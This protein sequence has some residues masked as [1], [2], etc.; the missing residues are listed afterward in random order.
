M[1][2][3]FNVQI[4]YNTMAKSE[5]IACQTFVIFTQKSKQ[6]TTMK[7]KLSSLLGTRLHTHLNKEFHCKNQFKTLVPATSSIIIFVVDFL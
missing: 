1:F 4:K 6:F 2:Y 7:K 5:D 3:N